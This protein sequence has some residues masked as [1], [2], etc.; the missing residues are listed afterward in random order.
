MLRIKKWYGSKL[1]AVKIDELDYFT[2]VISDRLATY[3]WLAPPSRKEP[4][5]DSAVIK[6]LGPMTQH[7]RQPGRRQFC[8]RQLLGGIMNE[9]KITYYLSETIHNDDRVDIDIIDK[10]SR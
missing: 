9:L 3:G 8:M 5:C 10:L 7:T 6:F 4:D 2:N 1:Q